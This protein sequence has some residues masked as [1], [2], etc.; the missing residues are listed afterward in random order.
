MTARSFLTMTSALLVWGCTGSSITP[1][2]PNPHPANW[3]Q[4]HPAEFTDNPAGCATCHGSTSDP[5]ASGGT[6]ETSCFSCHN[7]ST[8]APCAHCHVFQQ[9]LWASSQ[10][11]HAAS[12]VDVLTNA[13]H[14]TAELINDNCL[15]CHAS[16][17]VPRGVAHFVTPVDQ[18]GQPAGTWTALNSGEWQATRCEVCHDP[19]STNTKMLAKYG[20]VLDGPWSASYTKITDL[21][22]AYQTVIDW[23]T[24]T[25]STFTFTDQTALAVQA[26]KLCSSCHDPADQGGGPN[27]TLGGIDYGPQGGDSRAYVTTSHQGLGCTNCHPTHDFTS[28]NPETSASC[29]VSGCHS[30]SQVGSL[31]GKVHVN[32]L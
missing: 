1:V 15:K 2:Q 10:D 16:F 17:Q 24:G 14:N 9:Q 7:H 6:S 21:P 8:N 3:V 23:S 30:T 12:S 22:A 20:A 28:A 31:P 29:A 11:L 4:A 19:Y 27:I 32:H 26:T 18:A 13:D 25:V 5:L